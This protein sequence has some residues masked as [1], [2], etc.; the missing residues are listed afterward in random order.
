[1]CRSR[2]QI[3]ENKLSANGSQN[4]KPNGR[5]ANGKPLDGELHDTA[6]GIVRPADITQ[7]MQAY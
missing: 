2:L 7:E 6:I 1:L 5:P 3:I 4:N